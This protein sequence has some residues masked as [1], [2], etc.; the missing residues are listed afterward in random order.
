MREDHYLRG[1]RSGRVLCPDPRRSGDEG[2]TAREG[3]PLSK[4]LEVGVE[5]GLK[6]E[7]E[8]E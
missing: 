8:W 2:G 3:R 1:W 5:G 4:K 7:G 6:R